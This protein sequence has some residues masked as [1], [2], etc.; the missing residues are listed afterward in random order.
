MIRSSACTAFLVFGF[1]LGLAGGSHAESVS[2]TFALGVPT[3]TSTEAT[4]QVGLIFDGGPEDTIEALQLSVLDG[5]PI[6]TSNGTDFSRFAFTPNPTTLIGWEELVPG[7]LGTDGFSLYGP[8]DPLLGP[9]VTPS[10][11]LQFLGTLTI[12]LLGL[13]VGTELF[14]TLAGGPPGLGTDVGGMVDGTFIPSFAAA[15]DQ[16]ARVIFANPQVVS[17]VTIPEPSSMLLL[18]LGSLGVFG[19]HAWHRRR[20]AS[21][22]YQR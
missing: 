6:L 20:R 21:R 8:S 12:N 7:L 2:A 3:V 14:V 10:P 16:V 9:F 18:G 1:C 4:F 22:G 5:D 19:C 11:D 13:P 17:F 15:D